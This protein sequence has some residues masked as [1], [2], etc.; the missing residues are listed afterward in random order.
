MRNTCMQASHALCKQ[1]QAYNRKAFK[2]RVRRRSCEEQNKV[3][4]EQYRRDLDAILSFSFLLSRL[5]YI[6]VN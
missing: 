6:D 4:F 1:K 2:Q 5:C 3:N